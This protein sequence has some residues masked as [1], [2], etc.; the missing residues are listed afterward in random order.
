[1]VIKLLSLNDKQSQNF[2]TTIEQLFHT[3][4]FTRQSIVQQHYDGK[5]TSSHGV[6]GIVYITCSLFSRDTKNSN[7]RRHNCAW[8]PQKDIYCA[9]LERI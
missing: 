9:A 1:M 2:V 4:P 3:L 8:P 6:W 7:A 5:H